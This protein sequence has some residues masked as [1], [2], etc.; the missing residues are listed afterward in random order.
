MKFIAKKVIKN[1]TYHYIQ[2]EKF[3]KF[4]GEFIP[5]NLKTEL[6]DFFSK[7]GKEK[8]IDKKILKEFPYGNLKKLEQIHYLNICLSEQ[9]FLSKEYKTLL[10]WY[11]I[12]FTFNSN[13]AEGSK[14]TRPEIEKFALKKIKKPKTK[15][16]REILNS[17]LALQFAFSDKMKWDL[18]SIKK[19]HSLLLSNLEDPL[20][21]GK[22]KNENNVAPLNQPTTDY[23][24]VPV[25]MRKLIK[26]L[27]KTLKKKYYP[28]LIALKFYYW[29]EG[30]HPFLDGNG[31]VG[32]I[33]FNSILYKYKYF[34][35]IF[36][37][38]NHRA[39]CDAISKA[40]EGRTKKL[41]KHFIDQ[42]KKT[43]KELFSRIPILKPYL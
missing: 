31:R 23:K 41:N 32:R 7:L 43:V 21:I 1:K 42:T 34:P 26:W 30:I 29:F 17:F 38:K 14:V 24:D 20:V 19:I 39:H 10:F 16:D 15:T 4:L 6:L 40:L 9:E 27:N 35:V 37:T 8:K 12:F 28:P 22:W 3:S 5:D 13:R 36:F 11:T 25:E 18:K 2:Y 33:L